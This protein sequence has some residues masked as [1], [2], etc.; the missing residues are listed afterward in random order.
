[1]KKALVVVALAVVA[2]ALGAGA[3]SAQ[4]PPKRCQVGYVDAKANVAGQNLSVIVCLYG[5]DGPKVSGEPEQGSQ[6]AAS[7]GGIGS[8]PQELVEHARGKVLK[9]ELVGTGVLT[10][11]QVTEAVLQMS[12]PIP[13]ELATGTYEVVA[14]LEGVQQPL[15]TESLE[16]YAKDHPKAK[17]I[18]AAK[19]GVQIDT[20]TVPAAAEKARMAVA[21]GADA[22][23]IGGMALLALLAA[24]SVSAVSYWAIARRSYL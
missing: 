22:L 3:A 8:L 20:S 18:L 17:Q 2:T 24:I 5:D 13:A 11:I 12:L 19:Q 23:R 16:I 15:F 9:L 21:S 14:T 7:A 10:E 6:Q 1:M 4:Y